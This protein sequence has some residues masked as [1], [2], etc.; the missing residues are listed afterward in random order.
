[1]M[2][3]MHLSFCQG[4]AS[5]GV[6][7]TLAMFL[8]LG[9]NSFHFYFRNLDAQLKNND[10]MQSQRR[11]VDDV[12]QRWPFSHLSLTYGPIYYESFRFRMS[13]GTR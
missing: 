8:L 13:W 9:G 4:N 1:M 2:T 7:L 6:F 3:A 12:A 11:P 10:E 5:F